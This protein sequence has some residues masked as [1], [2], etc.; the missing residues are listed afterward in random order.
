MVCEC[1]YIFF[2]LFQDTDFDSLGIKLR[3]CSESVQSLETTVRV[4]SVFSVCV[5]VCVTCTC[6]CLW[7]TVV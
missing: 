4:F 7:C 3:E 1:V 5:C 6:T 2:F